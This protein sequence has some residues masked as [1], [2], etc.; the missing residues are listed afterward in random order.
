MAAALQHAATPPPAR[1]FLYSE[2]DFQRVRRLIRERAGISL[3]P[4]RQ[5][6]VYSRLA[7]RLRAL[8]IDRF[9]TY[10]DR[11]EDGRLPDEWE[12]FTNALTTNLTAFFREEH[13]F[14]VLADHLLRV[15]ADHTPRIWCCAASTGEEPWSIAMTV[16]D[17]LGPGLGKAKLLA[18]DLDTQVLQIAASGVYGSERV[19]RLPQDQLER[20][21]LRG[22]GANAG[23]VRVRPELS[24]M[25]EFF[26]LNLLDPRYDIEGPFDAIFCRNVLIYFDK[27]TQATILRRFMP[28]LRDD[29][30]LFIGH[31]ES[32][33]HVADILRLRGKTV[34]EK[35]R[36]N[37][38]TA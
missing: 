28:L 8:G 36:R 3:A 11:L 1:D 20:H 26:Q 24:R 7:R 22:T 34:Y 27:Q 2:A 21:F 16:A 4:A 38:G 5:D 19:E 37:G 15:R 18:S 30:L 6:M 31:S 29:G 14:P 9:E 13:H 17:T 12:A 32:L 25:V 35:A 23:K 10:L 33:Y